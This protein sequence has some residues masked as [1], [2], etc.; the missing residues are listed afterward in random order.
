MYYLASYIKTLGRLELPLRSA[1]V[2]P[3]ASRCVAWVHRNTRLEF[4]IQFSGLS[5]ICPCLALAHARLPFPPLPPLPPRRTPVGRR[6]RNAQDN[7]GLVHRREWRLLWSHCRAIA[8]PARRLELMG[9]KGRKPPMASGE[10]FPVLVK[11]PPWIVQPSGPLQS[12]PMSPSSK[13][14]VSSLNTQPHLS[15][16]ITPLLLTKGDIPLF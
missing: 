11:I 9:I 16:L 2:F 13:A 8:F 7:S 1:E 15:S 4:V 10:S 6:W 14:E 12:P 5:I 3:T